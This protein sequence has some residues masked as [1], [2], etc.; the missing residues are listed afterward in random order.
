MEEDIIEEAEKLLE[1]RE[2]L[3]VIKTLKE[4]QVPDAYVLR[5]KA[6]YNLGDK[7]N[8]IKELEE[9]IKKFPYSHYLYYELA[10]IFFMENELNRAL[11]EIE[12]A[13]SII[14]YSYD[15]NKLKAKILFK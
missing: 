11:D 2:N 12:K 1:K 4:I 3:E 15:Y 13:L 10:L 5:S 9:G 14:P 6:Y 7:E 8:A